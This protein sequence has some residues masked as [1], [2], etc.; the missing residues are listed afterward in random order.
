MKSR[1][2]AARDGSVAMAFGAA[3]FAYVGQHGIQVLGVIHREIP[4]VSVVVMTGYSSVSDAVKAMKLGAFD[5]LS[6]PFSDEELV[7]TVEKA[8]KTL[9][10]AGYAWAL[11]RLP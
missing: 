4:K 9:R 10:N 5:Y 3:A 11:P 2:L 6:K 1:P 7:L 8:V